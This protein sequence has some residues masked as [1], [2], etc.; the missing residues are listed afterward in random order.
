MLRSPKESQWNER[1]H[2]LSHTS[3]HAAVCRRRIRPMS[4][5]VALQETTSQ[6]HVC[7]AKPARVAERQKGEMGAD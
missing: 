1:V 5:Q 2:K 4:G 3:A 7:G 6:R